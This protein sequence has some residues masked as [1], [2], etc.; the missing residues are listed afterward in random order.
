MTWT[1]EQ[2]EKMQRLRQ[3]GMSV[4]AI[5]EAFGTKRER[6]HKLLNGETGPRRVSR[7]YHPPKP[8]EQAKCPDVKSAAE[9]QALEM[10]RRKIPLHVIA[11]TTRLKYKEIEALAEQEGR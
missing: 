1:L 9:Y 4:T 10:K 2:V 11:A 6:V 8:A 7:Q 5:A 3:N